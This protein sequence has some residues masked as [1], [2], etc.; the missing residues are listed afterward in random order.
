M[1]AL[2][3]VVLGIFALPRLPIALLPNFTQPVVTVSINYPNV[4][5]QQM[6]TLITRPIENAVSRV[7][8][9]QQINSSSSEGNTQVSRAVLLRHQHRYG[10]GRRARA[11]LA[12]LR[13]AAERSQSPTARHHEVRF[14]LACRSFASLSPIRI[15]RYATWATFSP[16]SS[17]TSS[18]R[19]TG[20]PQ[21]R[22]AAI[23]SARS[24]SQPDARAL[25]VNGITLT[26]IMQR[27][28]QENVNLPAGVVQVGTNEYLVRSSALLQSAQETGDLIVTTKNGAP[29]RLDQV[30]KVTDSIARAAHA[31]SGS[32]ACRPSA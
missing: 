14:E 18:P 2:A 8:G 27:I 17:P 16:T 5:P 3:I 9:I 32:T 23:S 25:A 4:G 10:C 24:W 19:S 28:A 21:Y 11:S 22:S 20:S 1:I 26:Q 31:S 30:A 6:E 15:C 12:H 29:I 7:N 13:L